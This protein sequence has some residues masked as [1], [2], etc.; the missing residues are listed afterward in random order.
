MEGFFYGADVAFA[1]PT[2]PAAAHEVPAEALIPPSELVPKEEGTHTERVSETTPIPA[3]T[4]ISPEGVIPAT[5]QTEATSPI[6]PFV[7]C[8]SDPF[9]ALS[10]TVKDGS[11][12]VVTLSFIPSSVTRGPDANL[13]SEES[14]DILEDLEDKPISKKRISD[15]NEE[16]SAP[17]KIEFMG[18]C[19]S[20]LFPFSL[21]LFI[22]F[23]FILFFYIHMYLRCSLLRSPFYSYACFLVCRDL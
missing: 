15:S 8:T 14:E 16:E 1:T 11:S 10:Q 21:P 17:L 18:M 3:R 9:A 20:F 6:L 22:L 5:A 7:I 13:S 23:Y 12:L 19:P 4:P 2:T